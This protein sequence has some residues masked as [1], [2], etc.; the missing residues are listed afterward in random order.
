MFAIPGERREV[1]VL[2]EAAKQPSGASLL[3]P[4][5]AL[6]TDDAAFRFGLIYG[7][8]SGGL[9]AYAANTYGV[10]MSE[11]EAEMFRRRFFAAYPGVAAYHRR[12]DTEARR[13]QE[14]R[15]LLGRCRRWPD[16]N[17]GLPELANSPDQ[18]TG[19]DVLKLAMVRLRPDLLRT[20]AR[21]VATVHDEL[22]VECPAD[23][24]DEVAAA[25]RGVLVQAGQE[26]LDPVPVEA[27]VAIG[28]NWADKA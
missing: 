19:A 6:V 11:G 21:L 7:M 1:N 27:D 16:T 9:R 14:T 22:V 4:T 2:S 18:G 15:T 5:A 3:A 20:G 28:T 26:L 13:A 25:V 17:M 8:G 10:S 24:A 12:Q 23:V